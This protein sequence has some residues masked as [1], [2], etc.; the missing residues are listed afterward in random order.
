MGEVASSYVSIYPKI[1]AGFAAE[2]QTQMRKTSAGAFGPIEQESRK[3][4]EKSAKTFG[5]RFNSTARTVLAGTAMVA[6]VKLV[7]DAVAAYSEKQD[8][9]AAA[10]VVFGNSFKQVQ[11]KAE[12][13]A[14]SMGISSTEALNGSITFGTY[15]KSAGLAGDKLAG[16][17]NQMLQL[18]GD[19]ASF[20]GTSP[21]QAIEAIG[22]ALRGET[23]PIR[24]YGVLI[25]DAS[26]RQQALAMGIIK[27]TKEALTPQQRVL[28]V[29]ALI[30]KQTGDAQGDY[31]R[32][33][34]ST[35]NVQKTLAA[36][37]KDLSATIGEK[38]APAIVA[39]QKAGIGLIQWA[40]D[41]QAALVPLI[42][43]LGTVALAIGGVVAI[44]KGIEALKAAKATLVGLGDAFQAMSTRAKIA[45][46]S[47]GAVGLVLTAVAVGYGMLAQKQAD[48][49]RRTEDFTQ[50]I[51]ADSGALG[52]NTKAA[53][54]NNLATAGIVS[55]ASKMGISAQ[56]LTDA[57]MGNADAYAFV[58]GKMRDYMAANVDTEGA[59]AEAADST[60][61]INDVLGEMGTSLKTAQ[62]NYRSYT[63]ATKGS[64]EATK[65][66]TGAT[67]TNSDAYKTNA[68]ALNKVYLAQLKIRGDRRALEAAFD[69]A[70]E[71]AKKN[72]KTL[73][74]NTPKGRANAQALDDIASAALAAKASMEEQGK[75]VRE[76]NEMM[77]RA[78]EQ[79][80]KVA[81]A[82]T[83][84][85]TK[86]KDLADKLG[87]IKS[88]KPV[89][90]KVTWD[91][92]G[93]AKVKFNGGEYTVK[94]PGGR[95]ASGGAIYGPG[96]NTSDDVPTMLSN[97]EHVMTAAEVRAAGGQAA[98][99][100]LR[101]AI[102]AGAMRGGSASGRGVASSLTKADIAEAMS[103]ALH[104][105][106]VDFGNVSA[107]TDHVWG[108]FTA[109]EG[110]Y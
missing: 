105:A 88:P 8:A 55:T 54:T 59:V 31:A 36:E 46:A 42:G 33:A 91:L 14:R 11:A 94:A 34:E 27:T 25:D 52:E 48:A 79:F 72:G 65:D 75:P 62:A 110:A 18:A 39:A 12:G 93:P 64:T 100:R 69:A 49:T 95:Y 109:A 17:S 81:T 76:V 85:A 21:E 107:I 58:Q 13:A 60:G 3:A 71:A 15:G 57:I 40:T 10:N 73:S 37:T 30:L 38:L 102:L 35:A 103:A 74:E 89:K 43:T 7:R 90:I 41:N 101:A 47:A 22:A 99:Y 84:S 104:G 67:N 19:M 61:R 77:G 56:A 23:E 32:T 86:A 5:D 4:G 24:A 1:S 6:A 26:T 51:E 53:I 2:L 28:A 82:M 16:F 106:R 97:G 50:A 45:T 9:A 29:Q 96:T 68:D 87:L 78:R 66:N 44:G 83:G 108:T 20:R 63:D 80:I 70:T 98:V 92:P